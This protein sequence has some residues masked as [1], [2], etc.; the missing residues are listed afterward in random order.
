MFVCPFPTDPKY[1]EKSSLFFSFDT[2]FCIFDKNVQIKCYNFFIIVSKRFF[3][4]YNGIQPPSNARIN[5]NSKALHAQELYTHECYCISSASR[6]K[7]KETR[8]TKKKKPDRPTDPPDFRAK[9]ANKTFL[10][11]GLR[12]TSSA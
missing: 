8:Q 5:F 4:R 6:F 2:Q 7:K 3:T 10:F 1:W 12:Y 11:L 9:R